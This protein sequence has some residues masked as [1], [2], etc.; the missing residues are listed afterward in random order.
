[1]EH[2]SLENP[3]GKPIILAFYPMDWEPV[4]REQLVLYELYAHEFARLGANVLGVSIDHVLCHAAFA[5]DAQLR[6]PLLADFLPRGAVARRFGVFREAQE[7]SARSLFVL[8][9]QGRIRFSQMY[10]DLLNPGVNDLLTTL[11]AM[12]TEDEHPEEA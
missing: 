3:R 6:F 1:M 12:A 11:E 9:R 7:V 2:S 4:S 10:P 5:R 8:D